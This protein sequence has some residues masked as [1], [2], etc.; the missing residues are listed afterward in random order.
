MNPATPN[1]TITDADLLNNVR[2]EDREAARRAFHDLVER[3]ERLVWMVC[4]RQL[5][6]HSDIEDAFQ[7]TFLRLAFQAEQIRKPESISSW[8]FGV[9]RNISIR[10]RQQQLNRKADVPLD[11]ADVLVA[12]DDSPVDQLA[13]KQRIELVDRQ[14]GLLDEKYR[15]PLVLF[16]FAGLTT[17]EIAHRLGLSQSAIE[18]RLRRGRSKLR[19]DLISEGVSLSALGLAG[20]LNR[21]LGSP[22]RVRDACDRWIA[23]TVE[24]AS[25]VSSNSKILNTGTRLMIC[26]IAVVS[27]MVSLMAVATW[28][29]TAPNEEHRKTA[30]TLNSI[31]ED[32]EAQINLA[33]AGDP[34]TT[35]ERIHDHMQAFHDHIHAHHDALFNWL[36]GQDVNDGFTDETVHDGFTDG[37][38]SD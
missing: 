30:V 36:H 5:H 18:G 33:E 15:T 26:K 27:S 25:V 8:L 23:T 13:R 37:S 17:R 14:L 4:R 21:F 3:Y 9:A 35:L 24:T 32:G 28:L 11:E 10:I 7:T 34:P 20:G 31:Q 1:I 29:H 16:Y 12:P 19:M 2:G 6:Q 38:V 22:K